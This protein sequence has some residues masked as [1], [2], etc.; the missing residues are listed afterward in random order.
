MEV[1]RLSETAAETS[2]ECVG[3]LESSFLFPVFM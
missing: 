3:L 1:T 2:V